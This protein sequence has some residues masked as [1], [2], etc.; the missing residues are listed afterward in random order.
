M[1]KIIAGALALFSALSFGATLNPIQL[2]NPAGST[3]GQSIVS[4]GPTTAPAWGVSTLAPIAGNTVLGNSTGAAAV[5]GAVS[6]PNCLGASSALNYTAG[7][8][9]GCNATINAITLGG[10]TFSSPGPIGS[11]SSSTGAFSSISTPSATIGGGTIDNTA[12]GASAASTG[13]FTSVTVTTGGVGITGGLTMATGAITP[14]STAGIAGTTTNNNA[15]AGSWGEYQTNS[16]AGTSLTSATAANATSITNLP[17]GD[18]DVSCVVT[19]VPAVGTIPSIIAAGVTTASATLPGPNIGGFVQF[20]S[21]FPSGAA[22]V[23]IAPTV[24]V[25]LA[26]PTTTF[27]VAQSTFTGGTSTVNGFIRARRVR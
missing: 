17:A 14:V 21:S 13:R 23:M 3:A 9:F 24:R 7:S 20:A 2:L 4:T 12:I 19:F 5:P 27:C 8:G 15:T 1:K 16:T 18:W 25:S 6:V 11:V 22:Q 10:A 26:S